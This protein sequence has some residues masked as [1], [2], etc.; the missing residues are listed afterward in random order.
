MPACVLFA[1]NSFELRSL[2]L[3]QLSRAAIR[4]RLGV[5]DFTRR[6]QTLPLPPLLRNYVWLANEMLRHLPLPKD[7]DKKNSLITRTNSNSSTCVGC[8]SVA[9]VK[10]LRG[11]KNGAVR[12]LIRDSSKKIYKNLNKFDIKFA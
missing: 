12:I 8:I 2:S 1:K 10:I 6:V 4:R 3:L 7:P 9:W 11:P 5:N